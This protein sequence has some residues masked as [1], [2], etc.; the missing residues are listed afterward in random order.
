[1]EID[2]LA[3]LHPQRVHPTQRIRAARG[4]YG[5]L[6]TSPSR[7]ASRFA[8]PRRAPRCAWLRDVGAQ[9]HYALERAIE[10]LG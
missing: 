3:A 1:M 7:H 2:K 5:T 9:T 4:E 8:Q 6:R 10:R